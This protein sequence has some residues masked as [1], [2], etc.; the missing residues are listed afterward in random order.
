[1][2]IQLLCEKP[3]K[4]LNENTN[5]P[6][7]SF[8][9]VTHQSQLINLK[10]KTSRNDIHQEMNPFI[11]IKF[12]HIVYTFDLY[13]MEKTIQSKGKG[14]NKQDVQNENFCVWCFELGKGFGVLIEYM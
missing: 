14:K 2:P 6:T 3:N 13:M 12:T 7:N 1:M 4:C 10:L 8:V 9:A 11:R 5:P